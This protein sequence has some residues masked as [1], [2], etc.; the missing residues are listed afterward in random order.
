MPAQDQVLPKP[1]K[2]KVTA[3]AEPKK[4][5]VRVTVPDAGEATRSRTVATSTP[6]QADRERTP[7]QKTHDKAVVAQTVKTQRVKAIREKNAGSGTRAVKAWVK[8]NAQDEIKAKTPT[9]AKGHGPG[10]LLG[11]ITASTAP[12]VAGISI[13]TAV[14][15]VKDAAELAVTTPSSVA[16]L[17]GTAVHDPKSLPGQLAKPY[18]DLAKHP[19]E[20]A[21]EKP[22][23][24][25]LMV[26]PVVRA[27]GTVLGRV[28]RATGKQTLAR[29]AATLAGTALKETRTGSRDFFVRKHQAKEDAANPDPV[30]TDKDVQRRVDE[31]YD[32][33]KHQTHAAV[34]DAVKSAK[35]ANKGQ[36]KPVKEAA[37]QA[38]R[39]QAYESAR[40]LGQERFAREFGATHQV[41]PG[42]GIVKPKVATEGHLHDTYQEARKVSGRLNGRGQPARW[43]VRPAGVDKFAVVP[44]VAAQRLKK[45]RVV[46]SSPATMAK[47]MRRSRGAFTQATLPLSAK[48]LAGQGAE[49]GIRAA[50]AG[51]GPMDWLR[52]GK[53]VKQLNK[54][55]PGAGDELAMHVTGGGHFDLTGPARDFANG[56]SLADEFADTSLAKPAR[57]ATAVG[58]TAPLKAVRTGWN[59]YTNAM[60][61][62]INHVIESN[63]RRAMGGQAIKNLGF[64]AHHLNGLSDA[65]I[66]DA[67]NG[68]RGTHNQVALARAVDRMYGQYSKF[69]PEMRTMLLHW[70]P[71]IAWS[72]NAVQF[73]AKVLP[74]DHPVKQALLASANAA[75]D[76]WR[77]QHGLDPF[78][79]GH[80]PAFLLGSSPTK[81]GKFLRIA[82]YTP[83]GMGADPTGSLGSLVLPQ[84]TGPLANA[85]G[86]DWKGQPLT[87]GGS[88]GKEFN[89]GEKA[90]RA[91]VTVLEE[92]IPGVTQAGAISGLTPK[93]VDKDNPAN[94]KSPGTVLKGYL[95]W[96]PTTSSSS[97]GTSGAGSATPSSSGRVK[98]PGGAGGR[99]KIPGV[100]GRVKVP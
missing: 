45:H 100:T 79:P 47:V 68:L 86:V 2:V 75:E 35:Q 29:P 78:E 43:V 88:H 84:F 59:H 18:V 76:D 21:E 60:L 16:H 97:Q 92:Q 82:H 54:Q 94:V 57:V 72:R 27:P 36:P 74:V 19:V 96:T 64:D 63:A 50:A 5:A 77:K 9:K 23:T 39:D 81:D 7:A 46:G 70:T 11:A 31:H 4:T 13:K 22:V 98:V 17:V 73:L 44:K 62:S 14:N 49:A 65:A 20:T 85:L 40:L 61:G 10:A 51:A 26:Q 38:A 58:N 52:M 30:M 91:L 32:L 69:S 48:W 1:K 25:A 8:G 55:H 95:P 15:A 34:G 42:G 41:G 24:T 12:I 90:L 71:Y 67:A 99:V 37:V 3:K 28:A 56:K 83:W 33:G 66:K 80:V 53:V 89:T 93:Y 87:H 6:D